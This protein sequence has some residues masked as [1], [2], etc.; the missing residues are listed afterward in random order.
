M[1]A[2]GHNSSAIELVPNNEMTSAFFDR[3]SCC[4]VIYPDLKLTLSEQVPDFNEKVTLAE[5]KINQSMETI[6][7]GY[8]V[9]AKLKN[10]K[11]L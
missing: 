7:T 3:L 10:D 8:C 4:K 5:D 1:L 11:I 6:G 2:L 9:Y